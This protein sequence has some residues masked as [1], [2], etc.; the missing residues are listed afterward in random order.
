[1]PLWLNILEK[2]SF[3]PQ[4]I[5]FD[6]NMPPQIFEFSRKNLILKGVNEIFQ[7]SRQK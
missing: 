3:F 7:F 5:D 2:I 6:E 1:M 4:Q